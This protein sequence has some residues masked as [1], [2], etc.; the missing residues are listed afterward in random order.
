MLHV[1]YY[2]VSPRKHCRASVNNQKKKN[3]L[4]TK[5][6]KQPRTSTRLVLL[7]FFSFLSIFLFIFLQ[8]LNSLTRGAGNLSDSSATPYRS[9]C[10][11]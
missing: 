1:R 5:Q 10:T 7:F 6:S 8:Q 3:P 11:P 2:R 4:P 9:S